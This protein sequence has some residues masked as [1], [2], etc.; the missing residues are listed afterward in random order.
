M[1]KLAKNRTVAKKHTGIN[2]A[3]SPPTSHRRKDF[4]TYILRHLPHWIDLGFEGN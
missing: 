1:M 4:I 3:T 2:T